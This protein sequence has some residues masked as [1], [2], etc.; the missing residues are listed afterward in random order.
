MWRWTTLS[1]YLDYET[2]LLALGAFAELPAAPLLAVVGVTILGLMMFPITLLIIVTVHGSGPFTGFFCAFAGALG[3]ALAG[4]GVGAYLG[5]NVVYRIGNGRLNV[6]A[7]GWR[8]KACWLSY[9]S[10]WCPSPLTQSPIW[11][12]ALPTSN[13]KISSGA[14]YRYVARHRCHYAFYRSHSRYVDRA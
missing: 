8:S 2:L 4:Y 10:A 3:C 13:S 5:R 14:L 11:W 7:C 9:P 1:E 12:L 6:S